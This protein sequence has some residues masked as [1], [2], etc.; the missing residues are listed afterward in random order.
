MKNIQI[1]SYKGLMF[2][3]VYVLSVVGINIAFATP[4]LMFT[5]PF[6]GLVVTLGSVIAGIVF[7]ARD[8][9]QKE[10]GHWGIIPLMVIAGGLSWLTADPYV[11]TASLVAFGVAEAVDY[12]AYTFNKYDF[13]KRVIVSSIASVPV[14]TVVFLTLINGMSVTEFIV[15]C[16]SKWVVVL[17]FMRK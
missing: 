8:Y 12:V 10:L 14:D 17:V 11:A 7:V 1:C 2:G 6:T 9:A 5:I 3:T 15:M 16:L 4:G 13:R